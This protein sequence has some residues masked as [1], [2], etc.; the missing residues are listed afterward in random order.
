[1]IMQHRDGALT[2]NGGREANRAQAVLDVPSSVVARPSDLYER[3]FAF[4]CDVLGVQS[5]EL[6][7]GECGDRFRSDPIG[8]R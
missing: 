4:T 6:R 5:V 7:D 2:W 1:M 8:G 3:L